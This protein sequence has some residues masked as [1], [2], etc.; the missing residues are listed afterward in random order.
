MINQI[1]IE[2]FKCWRE[3]GNVPFGKITGFFGTNS[4]GKTALLQCILMLKQTVESTDRSRVL[5]TGDER[6]YVELGTVYD[7]VY[8]HALP[9]DLR[10]AIGW[11]RASPLRVVDP[12]GLSRRDLFRANELRFDVTILC[13]A[14]SLSVQ[15]FSY[16]VQHGGKPYRFGMS[17]LANG[18]SAGESSYQLIADEYEVR[19]QR[20][21]AW[22]LPAPVKS[23]GFPD[24]VNAYFQ[25]AGFLSQLTLAFEELFQGVY[26]LGPLREY[27]HRSY[28]WAGDRPQDVGRRGEL[29][30]HAILAARRQGEKIGRGR[31]K[32]QQ[33]LE[34][35]VAQWLQD[36]G[37]IHSFALRQIAENR[38]EYEVRVRRSPDAAEVA[39]TDV[40]F[41]VSQVL[42]VLVLCYYAP[43]HSTIILEQPE[44][45]LHPEVQAGLADVF[46]D[47]I[48]HRKVQIIVESHSEHL[49][50]RLQRRVAEDQLRADDVALYFVES[51]AGEG[52]LRRLELDL[53]GNI[54]NWPVDFF[55]DEMGDLVAQAQAETQR[56]R[57][58]QASPS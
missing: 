51:Q 15:E 6:T 49:L 29:A 31:G 27:P 40:G 18:K 10:I 36:L 41:G 35:R 46:I 16:S 24:Q 23:Y 43:Q 45:H 3:T 14:D 12:E 26:Y 22:P 33:T 32:P 53:F 58:D 55:G 48:E 13:E 38:Q 1:R 4:S 5:H 20:G 8:G 17:R 30:V 2:R 34:E 47:A 42:P 44:I 25:N 37:M 19:R 56:R 21:R 57:K 7:I 9:S 50:R 11:S 52:R 54:A 28:I 39:I